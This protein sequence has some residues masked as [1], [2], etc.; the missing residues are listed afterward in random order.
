MEEGENPRELE[1]QQILDLMN[2]IAEEVFIG[3]YDS[4]IG[5]NRIESRLQGGENLPMEHVKA[6]RMS[7][8]EILYNWLKYVQQI[9][10]NYFIMQ[11][12]PI[13]EEKLF[14][15]KFPEP[16]WDRLRTF[17]RNLGNLPLWVN[18]ELSSPVFGGKQNYEYWQGIFEKGTTAQGVR[19]LAEPINLMKMIQ[20]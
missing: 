18:K 15:Y 2:I 12:T 20:P 7:K 1:K 6:F 11:G 3:K 13:R 19:V 14:Q 5:T 9:I 4:D 17:I 10:K 16:L 8:E